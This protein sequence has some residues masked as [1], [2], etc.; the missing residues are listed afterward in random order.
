[1]KNFIKTAFP[2]FLFVVCSSCIHVKKQP[3]LNEG[4]ILVHGLGRGAGSMWRIAG[5]LRNAGYFVCRIDYKSIRR[6]IFDIKKEVY[7]QMNLCFKNNLKKIHFVGHSLGG[8]LIRSYLSRYKAGNLGRVVIIA[9]PNKG[10][11]WVDH[12]KNSWWFQFFG[13]SV[14][15]LSSKNSD[16]LNSLKPPYYTLGVI[17]GNWDASFLEHILPGPDDGIVRVNSAKVEGMADFILIE[18]TTHGLMRYNRE[19]IDQTIY[20]LAYGKFKRNQ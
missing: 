9:S 11:E 16:F 8:L 20:F 18:G 14:L 10:S 4:V 13:D 12:Y 5:S 2:V 19:V 15:N 6:D 17:A 7:R 3:G 1:M